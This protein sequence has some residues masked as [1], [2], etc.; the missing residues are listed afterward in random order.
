[1]VTSRLSLLSVGWL[2]LKSRGQVSFTEKCCPGWLT[3]SWAEL[4]LW[5]QKKKKKL[6]LISGLTN[7]G[8]SLN[9]PSEMGSWDLTC[10]TRQ[11]ENVLAQP[12]VWSHLYYFYLCLHLG[13][14][15]MP[16]Q[17]YGVTPWGV[18]P[19]NLFQQ[20][21]AAANNSANQQAANQGQQNQQQVR[22]LTVDH[23]RTF[24]LG[25]FSTC[26]YVCKNLQGNKSIIGSAGTP[27][28]FWNA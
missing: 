2:Q 24:N 3:P 22:K 15:V 27:Q 12:V 23:C 6:S 13:P 26:F 20:Q 9:L 10:K 19:A 14:A 5:N 1:M 21:A 4:A 17:Y 18:Y 7:S 28:G 8:F 11:E 16:P 25:F